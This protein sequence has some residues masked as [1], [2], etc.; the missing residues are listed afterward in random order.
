M[1]S[2]LK[3]LDAADR[4][5]VK[6]PLPEDTQQVCIDLPGQNIRCHVYKPK[7]Q[8]MLRNHRDV[9]FDIAL[10]KGMTYTVEA[11]QSDFYNVRDKKLIEVTKKQKASFVDGERMHFWVGR[12][13]KGHLV[14]KWQGYGAIRTQ[15][16][17]RRQIRR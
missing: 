10:F 2:I 14:L 16:T 9:I 3:A 17:G 11:D 13:F 4:K 15:C 7:L 6:P 8:I 12:A 1:T 5:Q